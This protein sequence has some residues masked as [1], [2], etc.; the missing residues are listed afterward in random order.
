MIPEKKMYR[1][2]SPLLIKLRQWL[3]R[4]M[5]NIFTECKWDFQAL[6]AFTKSLSNLWCSSLCLWACSKPVSFDR[7]CS[8]SGL[9][10]ISFEIHR[11]DIALTSSPVEPAVTNMLDVFFQRA[12]DKILRS[13]FTWFFLTTISLN[14]T[15]VFLTV[16]LSSVLIVR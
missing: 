12:T 16:S 15:D 5:M 14:L 9:L 6:L 10:F 3:G 13:S 11:I 8:T 4:P 1:K 7:N 2:K